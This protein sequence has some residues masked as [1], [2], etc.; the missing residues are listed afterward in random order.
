[1]FVCSIFFFKKNF[2]WRFFW[3]KFLEVNL[4][5]NFLENVLFKNIFPFEKGNNLFKNCHYSIK[6]FLLK[7]PEKYKKIFP[8]N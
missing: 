2:L 6:N 5:Q 3:K 8:E 1:M 4:Q 7:N